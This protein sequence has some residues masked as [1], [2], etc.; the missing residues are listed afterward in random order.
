LT[1]EQVRTAAQRWLEDT[2]GRQATGRLR[3][4]ISQW[5][6]AR[7]FVE[8]LEIVSAFSDRLGILPL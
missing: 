4:V 5:D 7:V 6:T 1:A 2:G 3:Q 8:K